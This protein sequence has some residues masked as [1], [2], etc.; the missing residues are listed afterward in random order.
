MTDRNLHFGGDYLLSSININIPVSDP[1]HVFFLVII[2]FCHHE[3]YILLDFIYSCV[4]V[5]RFYIHKDT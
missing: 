2:V 4:C 1:C 3:T 5:V